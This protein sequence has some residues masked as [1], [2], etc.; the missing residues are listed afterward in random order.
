MFT[1]FKDSVMHHAD[2]EGRL[3]GH[4]IDQLFKEHGS[5]FAEYNAYLGR[6]NKADDWDLGKTVLD[7]LG[8]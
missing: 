7:W 6:Q 8:Y 3:Q 2:A 5:D 1:S 4:I